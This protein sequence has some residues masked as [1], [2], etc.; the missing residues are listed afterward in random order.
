VAAPG[1]IHCLFIIL[2]TLRLSPML[3]IL[4]GLVSA[5]GYAAVYLITLKC[6]P[7]NEYRSVLPPENYIIAPIVILCA[8]VVAA[9]VARRIRQHVM[10]ALAAAGHA[11]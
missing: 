9:V 10:D 1:L 7:N 6:A 3:C 4:S 8:G 5:A 11:L 2:T